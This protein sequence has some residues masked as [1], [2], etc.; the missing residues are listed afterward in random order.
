MQLLRSSKPLQAT[1]VLASFGPS[2]A[3]SNHVFNLDVSL[4]PNVPVP[5]Y[6]KPLRYGKLEDIHHIFRLD[7][8]SP[9]KIISLVFALAVLATVP[10]LL[11]GVRLSLHRERARHKLMDMHSGS[12][13]VRMSTT[14]RKR[15]LRH[16][17]RTPS[18]LAPSLPLRPSSSCTMRAG[19]CSK[20]CPL[21][22]P[23]DWWR[24]SV[25]ARLC[26]RYRAGV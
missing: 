14:S 10:A 7:P 26:R 4:D 21:R 2:Q 24:S 23:L 15:H 16:R 22:G 12:T 3:F 13:L 17:Y 18:S 1:L 6:E 20:L 11:G 9:P 8:T 25:E 5:P 19:I